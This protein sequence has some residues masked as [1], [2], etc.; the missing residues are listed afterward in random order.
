MKKNASL[1]FRL[2]EN[3]ISAQSNI[4]RKT[5]EIT[6]KSIWTLPR[7]GDFKKTAW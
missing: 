7:E 2:F 1:W 5:N 3:K 6:F 4:P